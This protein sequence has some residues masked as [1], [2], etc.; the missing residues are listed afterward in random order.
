MNTITA[1]WVL[2]VMS[3]S[4]YLVRRAGNVLGRF[5]AGIE[6][7]KSSMRK[8]RA[9]PVIDAEAAGFKQAVDEVSDGVRATV[10]TRRRPFRSARGSRDKIMD[11]GGTKNVLDAAA[12]TNAEKVTI[13]S[14]AVYG[15]PKIHPLPARFRHCA[16]GLWR[17]PCADAEK[18]CDAATALDVTII[19]PK[20]FTGT[21]RLLLFQNFE[22]IHEGH[23]IPIIAPAT[24]S[25]SCSR[26]PT[27]DAIYRATGYSQPQRNLQHLERRN[28]PVRRRFKFDSSGCL[29]WCAPWLRKRHSWLENQF[30][31][32][33]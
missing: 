13:S 18:E 22:W 32:V 26:L 19:R 29:E 8:R 1:E 24:T 23:Q 33:P 21:G 16:A 20:T 28:T 11:N 31:R 9:R 27:N 30:F 4:R 5:A 12:A 10:H 6:T 25:I 15:V 17:Y 3:A 14:T 2:V 7:P